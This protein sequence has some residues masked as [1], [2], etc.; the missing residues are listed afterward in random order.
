MNSYIFLTDQGYTFQPGSESDVPEV[1]NLQVLGWC[2]GESPEA[3]FEAMLKENGWLCD[4]TFN[5]C[6]SVE[7]KSSDSFEKA[8]HFQL[9]KRRQRNRVSNA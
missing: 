9:K 6:F 8:Q 4:T 7:L 2:N 1:G 3:A 5:E